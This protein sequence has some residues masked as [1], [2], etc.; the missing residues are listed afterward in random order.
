MEKEADDCC[1]GTDGG[2]TERQEEEEVE[3]E[4]G[5]RGGI[6][7]SSVRSL[8]WL[9]SSATLS[10]ADKEMEE[11]GGG[12]GGIVGLPACNVGSDWNWMR[13][14]RRLLPFQS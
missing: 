10:P 11:G 13:G 8:F 4:V 12:G 5:K 3:T 1:G 14:G 6:F 9:S 7:L 2:R